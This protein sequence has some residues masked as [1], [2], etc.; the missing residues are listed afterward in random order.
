MINPILIKCI[1]TYTTHRIFLFQLNEE[2]DKV[3]TSEMEIKLL[4]NEIEK[5]L[6]EKDEEKIFRSKMAERLKILIDEKNKM[7]SSYKT[8]LSQV[9]NDFED[10]KQHLI[11][12]TRYR[13]VSPLPL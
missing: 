3:K 4:K 10:L 8:E 11:Y 12:I 9:S 6:K 13:M 5:I 2:R 1:R 7:E